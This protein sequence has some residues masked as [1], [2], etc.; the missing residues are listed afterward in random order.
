MSKNH[1]RL[2]VGSN[3]GAEG[4]TIQFLGTRNFNETDVIFVTYLALASEFLNPGNLVPWTVYS[5]L[6]RRLTEL[7]D[8][9]SRGHTLV[10]IGAFSVPVAYAT[11]TNKA[12]STRLE[13]ISPLNLVEFT[14]ASGSRVE[15]CGPPVA[16]EVFSDVLGRLKYESL[17]NGENFIPLLRVAA[18]TGGGA[19]QVVGGYRKIGLGLIVYVPLFSGI[20]EQNKAYFDQLARLASLLKAAATELPDWVD[21]YQS[22]L[23][24]VSAKKIAVLENEAS[25]LNARI[26]AERAAMEAHKAMKVLLAG[27]GSAFASAVADALREL[28]LLV[29][30]GPHPRADLLSAYGNRFIAVEAKGVDGPVRETQFRQTE[31]WVAEV[32]STV[33]SSAEEVKA[34]PD[35]DRYAAELAKL[36]L[37]FDA[38]SDDCKGLLI[39]GTF[40]STPLAERNSPD[41]PEPVARLLNR[42]NV[43]GLT[44]AQLYSLVMEARLN[45]TSK[46]EIL[47]EIMNT[48]GVLA[49]GQDWS[50]YLTR[51]GAA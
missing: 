20:S 14:S 27:T 21:Q 37:A 9:I 36:H 33:G 7:N 29:V 31:R 24:E 26:D 42:S 22:E 18:A 25:D 13:D 11:D 49:R 5:A 12:R 30:D 45:P 17:L 1:Q 35:L 47:E 40:R 6:E 10:V 3:Y 51:S 19:S 38:L 23:E 28:G 32:N 43:C 48:C 41:F 8:W 46:Q 16:E 4:E 2:F 44:G 39:V 34:D 15:Y 50:R